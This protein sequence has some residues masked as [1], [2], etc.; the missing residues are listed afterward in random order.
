MDR[1]K[2]RVGKI[3][4]GEGAPGFFEVEPRPSTTLESGHEERD[5]VA[6][7]NQRR[8][9]RGFELRSCLVPRLRVR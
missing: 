9:Q 8:A 7:S 5:P 4:S 1:A 6:D 2:V 3:V